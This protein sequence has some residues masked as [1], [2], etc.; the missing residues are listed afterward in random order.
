MRGGPIDHPLWINARVVFEV[1]D[2]RGRGSRTVTL[3][4]PFGLIGSIVGADITISDT[5]VS[6]RH[7]YIHVDDRGVCVIDLA[8]RTGIRVNGEPTQCAWLRLGDIVEV[9]GRELELHEVQLNGFPHSPPTCH[10]T[11]L[12]DSDE[13]L[14]VNLSLEP[15]NQRGTSWVIGSELIF[16][17]QGEMCGIR[18]L[19]S[20]AAKVHCALLRAATC[21]YVVDLLVQRTSVNHQPIRRVARLDD[22]D[23]LSVGQT[24]FLVH[25]E[26]F[27]GEVSA[28]GWTDPG[29]KAAEP[30][31]TIVRVVETLP[32]PS[33][34]TPF[35]IATMPVEAQQA[36]ANWVL[37]AVEASHGELLRR[38]NELQSALA[39]V[40]RHIQ[41]DSD[42]SFNTHDERI[43]ALNR[44]I[45]ELRQRIEQ[46]SAGNTGATSTQST[47]TS[48]QPAPPPPTPAPPPR[49]HPPKSP[50]VPPAS[51]P[52]PSVPDQPDQGIVDV[53]PPSLL[54]VQPPHEFVGPP[55][56]V[57]ER[58]RESA[59]WL[60]SRIDQTETVSRFSLKSLF[61][62]GKKRPVLPENPP[63]QVAEEDSD[64]E[65]PP[66]EPHS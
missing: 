6:A 11:L 39:Q 24:H 3:R 45:E 30:A 51:P 4:K 20:S 63:F 60:L 56:P 32:L 29:S 64:S 1:R 47:T 22:G 17:G 50:S 55:A 35:P 27:S 33:R 42:S 10:D 61:S 14:R 52:D 46:A 43:E 8:T 15:V 53:G 19:T 5:T 31:A 41:E 34:N 66:T 54:K 16:I 12:G 36:I 37:K 25:L 13:R 40:L 18:I 38:Q 59:T 44:E 49:E 58:S 57:S 9:A 48:H 62:R 26:P 23:L 7:A 65:S 2:Q 28:P 21:G